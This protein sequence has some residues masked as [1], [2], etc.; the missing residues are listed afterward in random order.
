M[1]AHSADSGESGRELSARALSPCNGVCELN[2]DSICRGCGRTLGEIA[3]W[4]S[5]DHLKRKAIVESSGRRRN[6]SRGAFTL[7]ELLVVIGII[8]LLVALLLPA[9]QA[10]R[11]AMRRVQCTNN[12]KQMGLGFHN[13]HSVYGKF[14]VGGAG[15]ASAT[16][17]AVRR[18]WRPSWGSVLL[19]FIEQ[20]ALYDELDLDVPYL[21]P[22]NHEGGGKIVPTYLCPSAPKSEMTRVNGDTPWLSAPQFG[23]TDYGGNYGER[24]LRCAPL[25]N[26]QNNYGDIGI[27][28]SGGRG[29]LLFGNHP[30]IGMRNILDG[31]SQTIILGEAPEGLHSIWIG[32]KNLFDQSAPINARVKIGTPWDS[33]APPLKSAEGDFCDYG[34]EFHGYHPG[35]ANFLMVDGSARFVAE[36]LDLKVFAA[37]LSRRGGE[38]IPDF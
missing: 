36:Q 22:I 16:N 13:Y 30:Q 1:D 15:I 19:P 26:C 11:E 23:R 24:A 10:A 32:H 38:V 33:C 28:E 9:I 29:V 8:G 7:I 2:D 34:Q 4:S 6:E 35:G 3:S 5:L 14:P 12:L 21:D 37:L 17:P 18:R 25:R 27:T 20:Q 31:S